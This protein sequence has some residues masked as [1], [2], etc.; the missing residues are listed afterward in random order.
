MRNLV[1]KFGGDGMEDLRMVCWVI[2]GG[3]VVNFVG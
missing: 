2:V 3:R 1:L